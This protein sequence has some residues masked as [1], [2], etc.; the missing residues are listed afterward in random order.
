MADTDPGEII[1]T[2]K[3][4]PESIEFLV[5]SWSRFRVLNALG[6]TPRTRDDLMELTAVSRS[7][8]SRFLSDLTDYGWIVRRNDEYEA[9]PKG[10]LVATEME[11]LVTNIET[12]E[13]LDAA[14]EWLPPDMLGF[15]LAHLADATVLTPS[16]QDHTEPMRNIT[17][18]I[19]STTEMRVV[20]TG[21]THKVVDAICRAGIAGEL[22]LHCVLAE[23]AFSGIRA[24]PDLREMFQEMIDGGHCEAYQYDGE[25]DLLD[26]NLVDDT[27]MLCGHSESG[28]PPGVVISNNDTVRTWAAVTFEIRRDESN[29]LDADAFTA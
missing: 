25:D 6:T 16:P 20:A 17:E 5:G 9:T 13:K 26:F 24:D 15:D 3:S 2:A 19:S 7:T 8:L 11:Q 18:Y 22:T 12:A 27:V 21:V 14:L 29:P 28:P 23:G 1:E 10:V 4:P